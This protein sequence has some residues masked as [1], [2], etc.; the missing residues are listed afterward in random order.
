[1]H[2]APLTAPAL[3]SAKVSFGLVL[4]LTGAAFLTYFCM[5]AFR[6]PFAAAEYA[7]AGFLDTG[8]S[9]KTA[10]IQGQV[11]G[12]VTSKFLGIKWCS[13]ASR[14][15]RSRLLLGCIAVA[16]AALVA[17][18]VL[19]GPWKVLA[20]FV[21]GLPLGMVWGFVVAYLEGRRTSEILL[22]GLS[23]SFIVSSGVVKD[24]G[25][26]LLR[27]GVAESWM[28]AAVGGLFLLPFVLGVWL[29]ERAAPPSPEDVSA[30]VQRLPMSST[31]RWRFLCSFWPGLLALL[32]VYFFLTAFRDYRDNYGVELYASLGYADQAGIFTRSEV[33]VA[34]GVLALLVLLYRVRDNRRALATAFGLMTAGLLLVG[35]ATWLL[36]QGQVN[37]FW[38]MVLI[39]FGSYLAYVPFG[40]ML[41]DRLIAATRFVGTAVFAIYLADATGYLG[42]VVVLFCKDRLLPAT[43]RLEF[44]Q[45]F[46]LALSTGGM[47]LLAASW[48]YFHYRTVPAAPPPAADKKRDILCK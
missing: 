36:Q 41:F 48:G 13:E 34:L 27:A 40:S 23:C 7:G 12:Y 14:A 39:G 32:V 8:E 47:A 30:R 2:S 37:G 11:I 16:E 9:L 43:S 38:W 25:V 46:C 19:P 3:P 28:P 26:A 45:A 33:P 22:A 42:S 18:A 21:N 1:V 31:D 15:N 5:Y 35:L 44:M 20:I 4:H 6:K 10:L 24:V 29:L 17:F